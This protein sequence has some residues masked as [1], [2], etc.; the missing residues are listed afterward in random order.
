MSRRQRFHDFYA[1]K[2]NVTGYDVSHPP[3]TS[4][5]GLLTEAAASK[6]EYRGDKIADAV[7]VR[8]DLNGYSKWAADKSIA[9]RVALLSEFFTAVVGDL[10]SSGGIYFR[11]EGDCVV[12]LFSNYFD[13]N[14]SYAQAEPFCRKVVGRTYGV[15]KLTA[16]CCVAMGKIAIYQKA[17]EIGTDDWSAEGQPFV[18]A[19]RLEQS[20]PSKPAIYYF[21]NEFQPTVLSTINFVGSGSKYNWLHETENM[22]VPGLGFDGGWTKIR[23]I[24]HFPEG[25][26]MP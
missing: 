14:F 21:E 9:E 4:A 18:H 19:A 5:R 25:R 10:D 12:G 16:K 2:S 1:R 17:H 23:V 7:V 8:A 15:A 26:T 22:Q 11:D 6:Y 3:A 24:D 13:T 20:V